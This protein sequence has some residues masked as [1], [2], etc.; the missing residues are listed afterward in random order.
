MWKK[1]GYTIARQLVAV[2]QAVL[3]VPPASAVLE[4]DFCIADS[5]KTRKRSSVDPAF[6]EMII[7]CRGNYDVIPNHI[8]PLSASAQKESIPDR[9]TDPKKLEEVEQLDVLPLQQASEALSESDYSESET[10]EI[11]G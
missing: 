11:V 9:L 1:H 8:P 7:F 10:D 2:V 6:V 3:G 4:R 5:V